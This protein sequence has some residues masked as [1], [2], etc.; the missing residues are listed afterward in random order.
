MDNRFEHPLSVAGL[1]VTDVTASPFAD[2]LRDCYVVE[3][4]NFLKSYVSRWAGRS[5]VM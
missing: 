4:A 2:A 5:G 1:G 3:F